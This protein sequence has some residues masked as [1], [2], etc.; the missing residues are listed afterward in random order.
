VILASLLVRLCPPC[1][2]ARYPC[3]AIR[4]N[5][6]VAGG[7]FATRFVASQDIMVERTLYLSGN[8]GFTT[9]GAGADRP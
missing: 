2:R 8:S 3:L 5:D 4:A 9:V 1:L 6:T 7:F